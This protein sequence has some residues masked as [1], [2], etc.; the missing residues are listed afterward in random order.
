M[1][2]STLLQSNNYSNYFQR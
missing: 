2:I 1:N